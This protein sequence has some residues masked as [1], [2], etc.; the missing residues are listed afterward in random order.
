M[1]TLMF[2]YLIRNNFCPVFAIT[3]CL[4]NIASILVNSIKLSVNVV[5]PISSCIVIC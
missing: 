5:L 4:V 2:S 1:P 3:Y